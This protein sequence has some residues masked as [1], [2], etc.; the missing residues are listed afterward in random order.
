[1]EGERGRLKSAA[2]AGRVPMQTGRQRCATLQGKASDQHL[3]FTA[4]DIWGRSVEHMGQLSKKKIKIIK[5][6][7]SPIACISTLQCSICSMSPTGERLQCCSGSVFIST[8]AAWPGKGL[9]THSVTLHR[10]AG[11]W[12]ISVEKE[13]EEHS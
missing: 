10:V 12:E 11:N 9:P 7:L 1:M 13:D 6:S 8:T 4:E 5:S 3:R 2:T